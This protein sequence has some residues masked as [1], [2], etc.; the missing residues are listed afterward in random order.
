MNRHLL[1]MLMRKHR[2]GSDTALAD[3][4]DVDRATISRLRDEKMAMS[5]YVILYVHENFS[6]PVAEIRDLIA[7]E[8]EDI[9]EPKKRYSRADE[10]EIARRNM[11]KNFNRTSY[12]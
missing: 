7:L 6:I 11:I 2:I 4:L 3:M 5:S 9:L 1:N 8:R 12:R 10:R